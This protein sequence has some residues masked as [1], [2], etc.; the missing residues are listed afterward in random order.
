[1][2]N[3]YK[4][5]DVLEIAMNNPPVNAFSG[6]L[7]QQMGEVLAAALGDDSVAAVVIRGEG[8]MFSAG[9]DITEFGKP[10]VSPLGTDLV[11]VIERSSKPMVAAISGAALGGGFELALA[12]HYR[13]AT[14]D[15]KLALPEVKLGLLPGAGGTQRLPRLI[16]IEAA[17]EFIVSG[18][19]VNGTKALEIGM[20]DEVAPP[21]VLLDRAIALA[22]ASKSPRRSGDLPIEPDDAAFDRFVSANARRLKGLDAP[23]ACIEAVRA[24]TRMSLD[25][26]LVRERELFGQLLGGTQSKSL[27]HLFA[28]ERK[29]GKVEGLPADTKVRPVSRVGIVGAGGM[30]AG[31]AMNFLTAGIP[32]T[33]VDPDKDTLDR[34][35]GAIRIGYGTSVRK[36]RMRSGQADKAM[37]ALTTSIHL[38]DLSACDFII[39]TTVTDLDAKKDLF[40]QLGDIVRPDG[41]LASNTS[42]AD[43]DA[44]AAAT[45]RPSDLVGFH[46]L[47][48]ADVMRLVVISRGA[49]TAPDVLAT[50]LDVA[51]KIAKVPVV[52]RAEDGFVGK[53]MV[54]NRQQN[55]YALLL[56]GATPEQVDKVHTDFGMPMGPFQMADLVG[57]DTGWHGDPGRVET[58]VDAMCAAG[59]F[60]RKQQA[61]FYDYDD[62]GR[63][64]SSAAT[65]GIIEG[66]RARQR[67]EPRAISDE[68]I[69]VRTLYTMVN[70]G[71]CF[72]A[73]GFVQRAS[74]IDIAW[75]YGYGW[76]RQT[77]GPMFWGA[78]V[79]HDKIIEGLEQYRDRL[80]PGFRMGLT[81]Q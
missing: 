63:S 25:D 18:D 35:I 53:H 77:G 71:A 41:I 64:T 5:D 28:A 39:D 24:S 66:L 6:A 72:L 10:P 17:L 31:I 52:I 42:Y 56:E 47:S 69:T 62:E 73:D 27:R 76:P 12:C 33:V 22:R 79:G 75:I 49:S 80:G 78:T 34:S 81:P 60:G 58:I 59:R 21:D 29:A 57:L 37:A 44:L 43:I 9:A 4:H 7:R 51:R 67:I 3:T 20:V 70:D 2:I 50:A 13:I 36:G 16:G 68:E 40:G 74:D 54:V 45:K 8:R 61:G 38:Q 65:Q 32:V 26:G 23:Q 30:G 14:P 46:F 11:K 19:A 55:A 1:M 48:P 15:A